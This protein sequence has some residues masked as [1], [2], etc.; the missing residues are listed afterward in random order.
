MSD[1]LSAI[2]ARPRRAG[3]QPA[4]FVGIVADAPRT[5]QARIS[6]AGI[7]RVEIARGEGRKVERKT[8]DGVAVVIVTLSDPRMST[9]HAR[10]SRLGTTWVVEDVG[11]KNGTWIGSQRVTRKPLIDGEAIVVGHT[12]LVFRTEGG[13]D[14]DFAGVPPQLLPGI[15]TLSPALAQRY[16]ELATAAKSSAPVQVSGPAGTGK[17][18]I[19]RAVHELSGRAGRFIAVNCGAMPSAQLDAELSGLIGDASGGTLFLD[20]IGQLSTGSQGELLRALDGDL[21]M[22][23]ASHRDLDIEVTANR[24]R[25]DLRARLV[26]ATIE[27]PPLRDRLEDLGLIVATLLDR[28]APSRAITFSV[29]ALGALYAHDWPLN[30]RELERSL[31][32]ALAVAS[33]RIEISHLPASVGDTESIDDEEAL[34]PFGSHPIVGVTPGQVSAPAPQLSEADRVLRDKLVETIAR[35]GGNLAAVARELGKDRTQIRRWMKRFAL[36]RDNV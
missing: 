31:S 14:G 17:E 13:E 22:I 23:S 35:H 7:D 6:L 28:L 26:G 36:T 18:L 27:L 10:L 4:L 8:I 25:A 11:S 33:D 20:E 2:V 5:P 3:G 9:K 24:F 30:I 12:A 15:A 16:Q 32:A 29:D 1:T 34:A 19:A 21:R